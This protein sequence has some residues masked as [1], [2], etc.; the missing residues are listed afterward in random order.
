MEQLTRVSNS[1][2]T[3][4]TWKHFLSA[5]LKDL[6][7]YLLRIERAGGTRDYLTPSSRYL[8][9]L[10]LCLSEAPFEDLGIS[11]EGHIVPVQGDG[12]EALLPS[13]PRHPLGPP[14]IEAFTSRRSILADR[15]D[16][17]PK[18]HG[19]LKVNRFITTNYDFE[20]ERYFQDLGYRTFD[21]P[22]VELPGARPAADWPGENDMRSDAIGR[23]LRD[24]S[25]S[26]DNAALLTGFAMETGEAGAS[27]F[28][29]HGRATLDDRLVITERDYMQLYLTDDMNR[30]TIDEGIQVAFSGAPLLFLGL[31]MEETDLLRPLR[32]FI[33]N[34]DRTIGYTSMALLPAEKGFA[35][36]T[37]FAAALYMRYGVHTIFYG[38]GQITYQLEHGHDPEKTYPIDWLHRI[39]E[40]TTA[41]RAELEKWEEGRANS[42]KSSAILKDLIAAVG[43]VGPDM[44]EGEY[45][46]KETS[47]LCV[48][49]DCPSIDVGNETD[50][51]K[52]DEDL[53]KLA[54]VLTAPSR[55]AADQGAR[56]H[57]LR[58]CMFAPT[59]PSE[60]R[61]AHREESETRIDGD[62]YL[63]FYT[64][65]LDRLM[66][67]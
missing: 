64:R 65:Q 30:P 16:P 61:L 35:A 58:T 41:L 8:V 59:R 25:F 63:G 52:L 36:R 7:E 27:V 12:G 38:S 23:V 62:K 5:S 39:L 51:V 43:T 11:K 46:P 24:T 67:R 28:H 3:S 42:R 14:T 54:R 17:L 56:R 37:K 18:I 10:G 57:P 48:L 53:S 55:A 2:N 15:F 4:D 50:P 31:G 32:Q 29:L 34:R 49:L 60:H 66:A 33:S 22:P 45:Y 47:A 26:P 13:D 6:D 9:S 21:P 20:I 19:E 44:A 1:E 40:L